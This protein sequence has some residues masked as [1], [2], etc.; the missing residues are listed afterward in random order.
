MTQVSYELGDGT[1]VRFDTDPVAG[2]RQVGA[3]EVIGRIDDAVAPLVAGAS[4][5][6][7]KLKTIQPDGIE[8]KFGV[9]VSGTANWVV[10]K[11]ATEANFEVTL[12]WKHDDPAHGPSPT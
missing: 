8:L 6:L 11:A 4:V 5:V 2:W 3:E 1:K 12:T 9:K 7:G 10:A